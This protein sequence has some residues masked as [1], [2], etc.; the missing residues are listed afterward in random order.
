MVLRILYRW[1]R[2]SYNL[3]GQLTDAGFFPCCIVLSFFTVGFQFL[4]DK[5]LTNERENS[6]SLN[7]CW[8]AIWMLSHGFEAS[9]EEKCE[10][11][12]LNTFFR[13][14]KTQNYVRTF[15]GFLEHCQ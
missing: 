6:I 7:R 12:E 3:N 15:N 4:N 11:N 13:E 5:K 2:E 10:N 8:Y 1:S 14:I 9:K